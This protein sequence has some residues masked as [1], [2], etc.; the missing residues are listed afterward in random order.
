MNF[1]NA[2]WLYAH[3]YRVHVFS[4]SEKT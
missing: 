3:V 1:D 2:M 4:R